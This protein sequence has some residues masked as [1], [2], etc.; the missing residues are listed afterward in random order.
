VLLSPVL[1][2][3]LGSLVLGEAV[4]PMLIVSAALILGGALLAYMKRS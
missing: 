1:G 3:L 2:I 4:T